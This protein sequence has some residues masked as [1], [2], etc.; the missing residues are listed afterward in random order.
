MKTKRSRS[1]V[2]DS[3]Q[4]NAR[5]TR[6][7]VP[8][9]LDFGDIFIVFA[10]PPRLPS[11]TTHI[12]IIPWSQRWIFVLRQLSCGK[13][14]WTACN[15]ATPTLVDMHHLESAIL[16]CAATTPGAGLKQRCYKNCAYR[17]TDMRQ[18]FKGH[19]HGQISRHCLF[20]KI[21]GFRPRRL[22]FHLILDIYF[23]ADSNPTCA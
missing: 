5:Q 20:P 7:H 21:P 18:A 1:Y 23:G 9:E 11:S 13:P 22:N 8:A 15:R 4:G 10:L 19:L 2:K 3:K 12:K 14:R 6:Q 17:R 16:I